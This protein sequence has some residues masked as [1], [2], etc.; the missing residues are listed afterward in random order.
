MLEENNKFAVTERE[1]C[2]SKSLVQTE[3]SQLNSEL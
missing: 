1:F 2:V 3:I